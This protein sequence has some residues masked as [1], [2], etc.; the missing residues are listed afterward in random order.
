MRRAARI[1]VGIA[2]AGVAALA[3]AVWNRQRAG[4]PDG[5]SGQAVERIG[6]LLGTSSIAGTVRRAGRSVPASVVVARAGDE[7]GDATDAAVR[8]HH[9]AAALLREATVVARA[10]AAADGRFETHGLGPGLYIVRASADG[11]ALG[12]TLLGIRHDGEHVD[13]DVEVVRSLHPLRAKIVRGDGAPFRGPVTVALRPAVD[14]SLSPRYPGY[15]YSS[16]A[17]T[18][19]AVTDAARVTPDEHGGI[20][21]AGLPAGAAELFVADGPIRLRQAL[22][23]PDEPP[24]SVELPTPRAVEHGIRLVARASGEPL[25][26]IRVTWSWSIDGSSAAIDSVTDAQGRVPAVR[27]GFNCTVG[28]PG[29]APWKP[30]YQPDGPPDGRLERGATIRGRVVRSTDGAPVAGQSVEAFREADWTAERALARTTTDSEGRYVIAGL[31]SGDLGIRVRGA[32]GIARGM[33]DLDGSNQRRDRPL[34]YDPLAVD[35]LPGREAVVDVV[36]EPGS[37]IAGRVTDVSGA[38]AAGVVVRASGSPRYA[39]SSI[40]TPPPF[41]EVAETATD[42]NGHFVLDG[43]LP[44]R[45]YR[46]KALRGAERAVGETTTL[47]AGGESRLDL[48]F[49]PSVVIDVRVVVDGTGVG[50]AGVPLAAGLAD[51]PESLTAESP[52]VWQGRSGEDGFVRVGPIGRVALQFQQ[53]VE[54]WWVMNPT[55]PQPPEGS[56]PPLTLRVRRERDGPTS[57]ASL[58]KQALDPEPTHERG[59][60]PLRVQVVGPDGTPVRDARIL[61]MRGTDLETAR[62]TEG[63][64]LLARSSD[65]ESLEVVVSAARAADGARLPLGWAVGGPFPPKETDVKVVL[66]REQVVSGRA[67]D[68][69]GR[70]VRGINVRAL[71]PDSENRFERNELATLECRTD[72]EGAFRIGGLQRQEVQLV[73]IAPAAY[74]DVPPLS[75]TAGAAPPV[76]IRLRRAITRR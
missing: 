72:A 9:A 3:I 39:M 51:E 13:V 35:V 20:E 18:Y 58:L 70:G 50:V 56:V 71:V 48:V 23:F 49:P 27:L 43:L 55:V 7:F 22:A 28:T 63:V 21:V 65:R 54:G 46:V 42:C 44:L 31:P 8:E 61:W 33:A 66:P 62:V 30:W 59:A 4:S 64:A 26:G 12:A 73:I 2:L 34:D 52:L 40:A 19:A 25:P 60:K 15:P 1:A 5:D 17:Q 53:R 14:A 16:D 6:T 67:I 10:S 37:R 29:F 75:L 69:D 76:E 32:A 74:D 41:W 24:V 57:V 11:G 45:F 36:M 68:A 47:V 38:P